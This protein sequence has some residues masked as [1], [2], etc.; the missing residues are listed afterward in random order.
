M[1]LK[2][3]HWYHFV[4]LFLIIILNIFVIYFW[5]NQIPAARQDESGLMKISLVGESSFVV[6]SIILL[7]VFTQ[8]T[9]QKMKTQV[10]SDSQKQNFSAT[11]LTMPQ[12]PHMSQEETN[13]LIQ[14]G[15][16]PRQQ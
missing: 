15:T 3:I 13:P 9:L 16:N 12:S 7:I 14:D 10:S 1:T 8:K 6:G 5:I 11:Q 2:N 4:I